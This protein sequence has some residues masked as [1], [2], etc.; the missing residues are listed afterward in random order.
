M[1][2]KIAFFSSIIFFL[3]RHVLMGRTVMGLFPFL[4]PQ[5]GANLSSVLNYSEDGGV[6]QFRYEEEET[7]LEQ[8][9]GGLWVMCFRDSSSELLWRFSLKHKDVNGRCG[10]KRMDGAF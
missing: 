5:I 3:I 8:S 10:R 1:T 2:V 7:G 9:C 6:F 4:E